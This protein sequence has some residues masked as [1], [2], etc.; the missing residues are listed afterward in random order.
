MMLL[1]LSISGNR[2]IGIFRSLV[3]HIL[4]NH[5]LSRAQGHR[6]SHQDIEN[7]IKNIM[8]HYTIK[9]YRPH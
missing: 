4:V 7:N 9:N 2:K 3:I 5:T 8:L 6:L 1:S